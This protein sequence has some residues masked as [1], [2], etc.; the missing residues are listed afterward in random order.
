MTARTKAR[1]RALDALYAADVRGVD[2]REV[3]AELVAERLAARDSINPY[4]VE[5]VEG[6][7]E[8]LERIYELLLTHAEGWALDR[9]PVVD[10]NL[11]R[12]GVFEIL[13][14]VDVPDAV[15]ASEA[16]ELSTQISTDD[17]PRFINGL[18]SRIIDLKPML[19]EGREAMVAQ[20]PAGEIPP[21]E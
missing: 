3:L 5:L 15:V 12:I 1:K 11:L 19:P 7:H 6:V 8:H 20:A 13:W 14:Q 18:L 4:T 9:M 21:S 17:S 2:S 16:V 10:R